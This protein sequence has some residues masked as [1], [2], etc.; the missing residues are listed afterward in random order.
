MCSKTKIYTFTESYW[1]MNEKEKLVTTK[2]LIA[3]ADAVLIGAGAGLSASAGLHY[4]GKA[5][6]REFDDFIRRYG[7]TDLYTSGFYPFETEEERWAYWAKHIYMARYAPGALPLYKELLKLVAGKNY[8][9]IT[10]NVD[11][12]FRQAGFSEE[13]LFEVQ[14]DYGLNQCQCGCHDTLYNNEALVKRMLTAI[15]HC[16]IPS[17]LVPVCPC[18][19]GKMEVHVRKDE[20]FVQDA[21][22]HAAYER[23]RHFVQTLEQCR[24]VLLLEL[25]VGFNTPTIIRYP[26]EWIASCHHRATLVR[27]NQSEAT[28]FFIES[29]KKQTI[30]FHEDAAVLLSRLAG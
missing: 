3:Q 5:F 7:F 15:D 11:A 30:A 20:H 27:I 29:C 17:Q 6:E 19:G 12:Q 22:W 2:Q 16:R 10:T 24:S 18:C 9:V 23:Y 8:F 26:F 1:D 4:A 21:A 14:G 25:G 13:R 28:H